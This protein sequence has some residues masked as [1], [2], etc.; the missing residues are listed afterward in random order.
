MFTRLDSERNAKIMKKAV[1]DERIPP[2]TYKVIYSKVLI[3]VL[4]IIKNKSKR[5]K[6]KSNIYGLRRRRRKKKKKKKK[7]NIYIYIYI[8]HQRNG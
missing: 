8:W 5:N 3:Y 1:M 2:Q 4:Q 6:R 7:K